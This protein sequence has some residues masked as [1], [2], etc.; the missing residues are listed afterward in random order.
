[1]QRNNLDIILAKDYQ[2]K[3]HSTPSA[4]RARWSSGPKPRQKTPT[5]F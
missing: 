4:V 5:L 3:L 1:M 2:A